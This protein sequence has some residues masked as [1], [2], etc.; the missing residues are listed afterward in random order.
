[1]ASEITVMGHKNSSAINFS[2][3]LNSEVV[4]TSLADGE[5]GFCF[6]AAEK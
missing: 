1:M 3:T 6:N 4:D 5:N 2:H